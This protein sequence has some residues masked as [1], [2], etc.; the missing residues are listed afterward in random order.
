MSSSNR[1]A[2]LVQI[3]LAVTLVAV[4]TAWPLQASEAV[5][6]FVLASKTAGWDF[7]SIVSDTREK[8]Q[9]AGFEIIGQYSPYADAEI[10]VFTNDFLQKSVDSGGRRQF[11]KNQHRARKIK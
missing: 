4:T 10:V 1:F 7:S 8:L 6:P 9:A 3:M 2:R 11:E 5:K